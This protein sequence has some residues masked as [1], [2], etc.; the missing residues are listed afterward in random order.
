MLAV[1]MVLLPQGVSLLQANRRQHIQLSNSYI[2][3]S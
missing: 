1:G 3:Y 2:L